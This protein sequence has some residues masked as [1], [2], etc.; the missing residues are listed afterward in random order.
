MFQVLIV[1]DEQ[2]VLTLLSNTI[3]WQELELSLAGTA[4]D[5]EQALEIIRRKPVLSLIHISSCIFS[6]GK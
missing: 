2:S 6:G 1:D 5:G 3:N 4:A